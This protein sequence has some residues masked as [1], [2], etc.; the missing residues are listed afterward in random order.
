[1]CIGTF[2]LEFTWVIHLF[3]VPHLQKSIRNNLVTKD[4]KFKMICNRQINEIERG[5]F[6]AKWKHL[7]DAYKTDIN[8]NSPYRILSKLSDH[9][10]YRREI[11]KVKMKVKVK[12]AAQTLSFSVAS[13]K[14]WTKI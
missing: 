10:V 2:D 5:N 7:V 8:R 1:M 3:D 13:G 4:L 12:I 14:F 11:D 6:T 9:H